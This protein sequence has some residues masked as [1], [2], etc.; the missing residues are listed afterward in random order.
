MQCLY[1]LVPLLVA[2]QFGAIIYAPDDM[3]RVPPILA[4]SLLRRFFEVFGVTGVYLP[5]LCVVAVLL[6]WHLVK[7]D[8]WE[9]EWRLYAGMLIES[10]ILVAPLLVLGAVIMRG[11]AVLTPLTPAGAEGLS[12][13]AWMVISIGAGIFEELLFRL[14]AIA[15]IHGL[16]VDI[17]ALP[18]RWGMVLAIVASSLAFAFYHFGE[19]NPFDWARL[20]LYTLAGAY[21]AMVYII[22]GFGIVVAVHA[23]YDVVVF[24]Q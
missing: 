22:R 20:A 21:L 2:Y 7:R 6:G 5:G 13:Q 24:L 10:V 3:S 16:L 23:L 11:D 15:A 4:E 18:D 19:D 14:I 9:P 12:W 1:F 8:P 17:L